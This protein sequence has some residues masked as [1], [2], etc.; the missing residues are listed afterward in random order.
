MQRKSNTSVKKQQ[1]RLQGPK[2]GVKASIA[3]K[4]AVDRMSYNIDKGFFTLSSTYKRCLSAI[5]KAINET[6]EENMNQAI[7][8]DRGKK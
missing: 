6:N 5:T 1:K 8:R 3:P 4:N 2:R 7:A